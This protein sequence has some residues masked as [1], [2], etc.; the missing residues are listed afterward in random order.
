M[1]KRYFGR[2]ASTG[3]AEWFHYDES[4]GDFAIETQS[5]DLQWLVDQ[6]RRLENHAD[7]RTAGGGRLVAQFTNEVALKW[8][9]DY[10]VRVWDKNHWP[11]VKRILNDIEWAGLRCARGRIGGA[12]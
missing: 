9:Q 2:E 10:G 3:A 1:S 6:N 11:R 8:F 5:R 7:T 12:G 4:T